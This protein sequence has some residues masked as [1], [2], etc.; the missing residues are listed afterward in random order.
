MTEVAVLQVV[1]EHQVV[2]ITTVKQSFVQEIPSV[3]MYH[4]MEF[5]HL[6]L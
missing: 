3:V 1:M 2:S 5:V 6:Q 4:G